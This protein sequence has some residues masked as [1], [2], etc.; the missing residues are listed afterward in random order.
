MPVAQLRF[1]RVLGQLDDALPARAQV[2]LT[3]VRDH[4]GHR[5]MLVRIPVGRREWI[6][7]L[8]RRERAA[9]PLEVID[10]PI[11]RRALLVLRLW[12]RPWRR[13]LTR[14]SADA[15]ARD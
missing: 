10:L 7:D 2:G 6:V 11:I 13:R 3:A 12:I 14:L 4:F 15:D 8:R 1:L 9:A 5:R